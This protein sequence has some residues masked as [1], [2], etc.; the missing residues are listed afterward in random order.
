MTAFASVITPLSWS[1]AIQ[2]ANSRLWRK[3]VLPVG[4][5]E[6]Q[7]RTLHF[8]PAYIAGLE[9]AFRDGAYDQVSF[10]LADSSNSHTNDP[11]RHRG[12][13]V[14]MKAEDDGLWIT[15]QPTER[16]GQVLQDNPYLGVSCRIVEQY[17][18]SDGAFYPA[19]VQ[20]ILGTLDPRIPGLRVV[21]G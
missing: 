9:R 2:L 7:G 14:D 16:G 11:E 13:I 20:H 10:Q 1:P 18:R 3:R 17:A 15:L 21:P 19:A 4:D 8:T 6:Y 5:V 12:T